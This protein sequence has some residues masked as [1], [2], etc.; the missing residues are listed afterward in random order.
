VPAEPRVVDQFSS[1]LVEE[2]AMSFALSISLVAVGLFAAMLLVLE[3]GRRIGARR[4]AA[5]PPARHGRS[6][7]STAPCSRCWGC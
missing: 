4:L 3:L 5:L 1:R 7:R 6:A 2:A